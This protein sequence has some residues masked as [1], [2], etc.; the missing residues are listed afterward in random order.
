MGDKKLSKG[1]TIFLITLWHGN[2]SCPALTTQGQLPCSA[3]VTARQEYYR[4]KLPSSEILPP[5]ML[6]RGH[7]TQTTDEECV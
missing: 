4:E 7:Q 3:S 6:F 2:F 5:E 1:K